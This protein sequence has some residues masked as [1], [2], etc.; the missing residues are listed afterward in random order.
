V[1]LKG[2][3]FF[4]ITKSLALVFAILFVAWHAYQMMDWMKRST[5]ESQRR[6]AELGKGAVEASRIAASDARVEAL[7]KAFKEEKSSIMAAYEAQRKTTGEALEELGRV[8]AELDRTRKLGVASDKIHRKDGQDPSHWYFFKK[9]A[10]EGDDGK[11]SP[12][13]W[14]MFYPYRE[15][16]EQWKVGTYE[17]GV[18]VKVVETENEDGTFN[19]YA[20]ASLTDSRKHPMKR[21]D[22]IS[23]DWEK[24][25]RNEKRFLLNPRLALGTVFRTEP[26]FVLN[27]SAFS[28][29]RTKRDVDFRFL[30]VGAGIEGQEFFASV[31]P[32][33]WNVGN[34]V[35]WVENVFV[36]PVLTYDFGSEYGYGLQVSVPF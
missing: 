20:E 24:V 7:S 35:P 26:G 21:F 14:A 11:E 36:G 4:D 30:T 15:P 17:I 5:D 19:R 34:V 27:A 2:I 1:K 12:V 33:S 32:V 31:E 10:V 8:R 25:R 22:E 18:D 23:I 16:G 28:Y 3:N 29:G 13:A 6:M 9:I